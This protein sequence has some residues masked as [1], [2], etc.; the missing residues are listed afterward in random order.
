MTKRSEVNIPTKKGIR[1]LFNAVLVGAPRGTVKFGKTKKGILTLRFSL[2]FSFLH[3]FVPF[4]PGITELCSAV[5]FDLVRFLNHV[6][7]CCVFF[8]SLRTRTG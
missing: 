7:V 6:V 8:G 2:I 3:G 5:C 1:V 4:V